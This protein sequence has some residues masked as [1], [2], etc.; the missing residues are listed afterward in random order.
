MMRGF[1]GPLLAVVLM[2]ACPATHTDPQ[3]GA[4]EVRT[5]GPL[6]QL[7]GP[8]GTG[9]QDVRLEVGRGE[10]IWTLGF[11]SFRFEEG[12][13]SWQQT[14][15]FGPL[16]VDASGSVTSPAMGTDDTVLGT[17]TL[18]EVS[19][20]ILRLQWE[21]A[22]PSDTPRD[23]RVR[24]S[25]ACDADDH[26]M[27]FG[28]H[29]MDM[30]HI[31]QAFPLW[32]SEPGIG[33]VEDEEPPVVAVQGTRH[34]SSY[35][36]PWALRPHRGDGL[37]LDVGSRVD[38]DLCHNDP[39]RW[40]MSVWQP[41]LDAYVIARPGSP[42]AVVED[43]TSI[44]G[45]P[46]LPP[47]WAFGA[48]VD[49]VRGID[50]VMDV[51][52]QMRDLRIPITAIWT[53]DWKGAEKMATGYRLSEEWFADTD[54]YPEPRASADELHA[55][56]FR[57]LGYFAPFLG[58]E[59]QTGEEA[60]DAG[61]GLVD[62]NGETAS[63]FG[64]NLKEQTMV[65]LSTP[66]GRAWAA[67][68]LRA[69][70]DLGYSGWM[71]DY[72]EWLDPDVAL[73]SGEDGF[74]AHNR[75]PQWWQETQLEALAD[76]PDRALFCRSGWAGTQ[77]LC[78]IVWTGDQ[79]TSFDTDDG[80][81]TVLPLA[82]GLGVSGVGIVTHDVAGYQSVGNPPSD[83]ELWFRWAGLA[84][85]TPVF[86]TH[87]GSFDLQNHQFDTNDAT[88]DHLKATTTEHMRLW[89]YR[90]GLAADYTATGR[91]MVRPVA[92]HYGDDWGRMDAW[93]LGEAMLVAPVLERGATTRNVTLPG[94][95]W[96]DW[97]TAQPATSG[98]WDA[99]LEHT[100]VFVH[101]GAVVPTFTTVPDTLVPDLDPSLNLIG[102]AQADTERTLDI[103]GDGHLGFVEA[104]G[105]IY[106]VTGQPSGE[107]GSTSET[108]TTGTIVLNGLT[109]AIDGPV[110]RT[111]TI[112]LHP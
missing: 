42:L 100:P 68:R 79:R 50:R 38:V 52:D 45:R 5:E 86:R 71:V 70:Y 84:A 75:Y 9:L 80:F 18:S 1:P 49:A 57:W 32:V 22:A 14:A 40:S 59:S 107:S 72:G 11:G 10:A 99:P 90:Y 33:K 93:L 88:L 108:L 28:S 83:Q 3:L 12:P 91:P 19:P 101:T 13:T 23:D 44:T 53:E 8:E 27:G 65:D 25:M 111:Y 51:A 7:I 77:G 58:L 106:T 39:E 63:F 30:D 96:F 61:I 26:F 46:E 47:A 54:L 87:H 48:W 74:L 6:L 64:V 104:D 112:R 60:L 24:L 97:H 94:G 29:A 73:A 4:F 34:A 98:D 67:T 15:T 35:P 56:G 82:M 89:P 21:S 105:T 36:V 76:R 41:T 92:F 31:G 43:L 69:S 62:A 95:P 102:L 85:Y 55:L 103:F 109:I 16:E 81:P 37:Y 17:L 20:T 78:P 66:A 110:E 2:T